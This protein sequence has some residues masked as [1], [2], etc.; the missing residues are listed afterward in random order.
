MTGLDWAV[1][2]VLAISVVSGFIR[3]FVRTLF[4][5]AGWVAAAVVAFRFADDAGRALLGGIHNDALRTALAMMVLFL[6][7]GLVAGAAGAV[8]A[9]MIR[10]VGLGTGDRV[11][12]AAFGAVRGFAFV[13]IAAVAAGFTAFPGSP[14]WRNSFFGPRLEAWAL[15]L[16]P[17]L[18]GPVAALIHFG[19]EI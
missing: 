13:M 2:A 6:L 8:C 18:P 16:K 15:E 19:T 11:L 5:L 4:G 14:I 7:V 3:G 12:G 1:L 10:A 17:L 9:R